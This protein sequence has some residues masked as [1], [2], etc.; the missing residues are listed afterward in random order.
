[1]FLIKQ[2]S[3]HL[4]FFKILDIHIYENK[5]ILIVKV[6]NTKKHLFFYEN[7]ALVF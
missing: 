7:V 4:P 1:M 2:I 6:T 3:S 5:K